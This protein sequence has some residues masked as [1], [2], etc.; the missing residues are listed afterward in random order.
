MAGSVRAAK[1]RETALRQQ[2]LSKAAA[3]AA[4]VSGNRK[5]AKAAK[6]RKKDAPR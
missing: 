5:E 4:A 6:K 3:A 2:G 1:S